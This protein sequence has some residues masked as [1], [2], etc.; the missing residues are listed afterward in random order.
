MAYLRFQS[1]VPNRHGRFP[2]VFAM[3]NGLRRGELLSAADAIWLAAANDQANALYPDPSSVQADCYDPVM[4]P[5]ARSWFVAGAQELLE[6]TGT[7]LELLDRYK[8]PWVELRTKTP[9]RIVYQDPHQVVA[10][11]YDYAAWP[12]PTSR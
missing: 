2:G 8:V 3:A 9:G 7:Y 1:A 11:P 12:F 10:V 6:M 4:N 5:G